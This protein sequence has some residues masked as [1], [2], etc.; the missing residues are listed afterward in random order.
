MRQLSFGQSNA[1]APRRSFGGGAFIGKFLEA[2]NLVYPQVLGELRA[3]RKR[4]H[5]MWFIFPQ[6]AGLGRTANSRHFAIDNLKQAEAYLAHPILGGRL[7]ECTE[8][9]LLHGP[10]GPAPRNLVQIFST[11][12]DLKFHSSMT[13]FHRADAGEPLFSRALRAFFRSREDQATLDLL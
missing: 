6:I 3:G 4:G 7:R 1:L 12:D 2:Q 5:W 13:L 10:G 9:V 8:S 11:P